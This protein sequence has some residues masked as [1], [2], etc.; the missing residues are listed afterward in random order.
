MKD[1]PLVLIIDDAQVNL[2]MLVNILEPNNF[3]VVPAE[4][5]Q[6]GLK[7]AKQYQ[8][9]IILLDVAM[10]GWDGYETC[11]CIKQDPTL[12]KIP[13]LFLSALDDLQSKVRALQA[14]GVDYISKPFE[15]E[16]LLAR[17]QTHIE[18]A[19]LRQNLEREVANQT[20][21]IQSL[22][23]ALQL[24]YDKAQQA[25]ILK[26]EF[27][28]NIGHEFRTP[29][30][31][32]LGMTDML[33]EDTELTE[34]QQHSAEVV[35]KAGK[36]LM[37]IL[38][39]MLT[40]A[41]QFQTEHKLVICDFQVHDVVDSVLKRLS[42]NVQAKDL[43]VTT[44]IA[45]SLCSH[46]RGYQEEIDKVLSNLVDNA[47]KFTD[48]GG[49]VIRVQALEREDEKQWVR[50]EVSD[51]GIGIAKDKQ[52]NLFNIFYQVDDFYEGIGIGLTIAKMFIEK[53][54]GQIG[55]DSVLDKGSTFW[56]KVPL[57]AV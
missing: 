42:A 20:E 11:R 28:R 4:N 44:E 30:N 51:T 37:G 52:A 7:I 34:E 19:H 40:F 22:L 57:V 8:P 41:D 10:P 26:T 2:I 12:K 24:S 45:P 38:T 47:I 5:G 49:I 36:Q 50:F 43:Q 21:K 25:S 53:M 29:M 54:G 39:N 17:V 32:I 15:Q 9:D 3:R 18:L 27:L 23:E 55:V 48:Q 56:F 14:G 31:V 33:L 1:K 13:I 35:K 16:E 6:E 46:Q